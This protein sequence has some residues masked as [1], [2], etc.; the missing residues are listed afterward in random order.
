M[1]PYWQNQGNQLSVVTLKSIPLV[2]QRKSN[3]F[4]K[5]TLTKIHLL[6]DPDITENFSQT[7]MRFGY[8][9]RPYSF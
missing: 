2:H 7:T 9:H 3:L 1:K 4:E 8:C 5:Q 6:S